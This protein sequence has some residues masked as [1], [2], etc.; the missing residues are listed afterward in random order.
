[1]LSIIELFVEK[2]ISQDFSKRFSCPSGVPVVRC[3][4]VTT[5]GDWV[6]FK[7]YISFKGRVPWMTQ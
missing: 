2:V 4:Q 1:M 5:E 3:L 6:C 7:K